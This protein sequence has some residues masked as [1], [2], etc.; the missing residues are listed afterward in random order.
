M[1]FHMRGRRPRFSAPSRAGLPF[2]GHVV[3]LRA[4]IERIPAAVVMEKVALPVE[5]RSRGVAVKRGELVKIGECGVIA[6]VERL[7]LGNDGAG[8][9][10]LIAVDIVRAEGY[11][12][13][14]DGLLLIEAAGKPLA[15]GTVNAPVQEPES[16]G[17]E[18]PEVFL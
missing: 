10:G 2:V 5:L 15:L 11:D 3:N 1:F 12:Q 7:R 17:G 14:P 18:D 16:G 4:V 13:R 8:S 9:H 6:V